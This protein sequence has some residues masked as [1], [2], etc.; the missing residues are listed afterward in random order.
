M[1]ADRLHGT[2][3][4]W[5]ADR[6]FGFIEPDGGGVETFVHI[7]A[8][9]RR[10][11]KPAPGDRVSFEIGVDPRNRPQAIRVDYLESRGTAHAIPPK[12]H[13]AEGKRPNPVLAKVRRSS[14]SRWAPAVMVASALAGIAFFKPQERIEQEFAAPRPLAAARSTFRCEGKT[15]CAQMRSCDEATFYLDHCPGSVTDGD[16]DGIPCED[17]WCGH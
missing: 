7:R 5:N 13:R 6:G 14:G 11:L 10:E 16:G 9:A 4:R 17:Q 2:V 1:P 15:R 3:V 8:F 12:R